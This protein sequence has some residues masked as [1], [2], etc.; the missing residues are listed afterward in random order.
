MLGYPGAVT[1]TKNSYYGYVGPS[2]MKNIN[3]NGSES[4]IFDCSFQRAGRE[5]G[6]KNGAGVLCKPKITISTTSTTTS[7]TTTSA[8]STTS[9]QPVCGQ[10]N[11]KRPQDVIRT[12][13]LFDGSITDCQLSCQAI[14]NVL[15]C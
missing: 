11:L 3:C 12:S 13:T 10:K 2:R 14:I 6:L 9:G 8:S 1:S 5:C 4:S 7:T 15:L